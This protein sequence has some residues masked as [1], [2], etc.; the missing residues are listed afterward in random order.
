MDMVCSQFE[1]ELEQLINHHSL[2]NGSDTPD[3]ILARF[4]T[5]CLEAWNVGLIRREDWYSRPIGGSKSIT[6]ALESP[7]AL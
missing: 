5:Q 1:K 6:P 7:P 3:F 4:M 2:E